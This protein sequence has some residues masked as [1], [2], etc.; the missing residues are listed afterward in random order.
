LDAGNDGRI[1]E[2]M[3]EDF[4]YEEA[5]A[6]L[7]GRDIGVLSRGAL[8]RHLDQLLERET[9]LEGAQRFVGHMQTD[10]RLALRLL[11]AIRRGFDA[12]Q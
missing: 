8:R 3:R 1:D 11:Q 5:G 7:L 12:V 6:E 2:L 4:D 9:D 10:E